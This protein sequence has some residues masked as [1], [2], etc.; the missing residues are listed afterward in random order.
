MRGPDFGLEYIQNLHAEQ[1]PNGGIIAQDARRRR[2]RSRRWRRSTSG[3]PP[4]APGPS[5]RGA[6]ARRL[7]MVLGVF[8][9]NRWLRLRSG[10]GSSS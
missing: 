1:E 9:K 2:G 6:R 3:S 5:R 8:K 4:S 7:L 10:S